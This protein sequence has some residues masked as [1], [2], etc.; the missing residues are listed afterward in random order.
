MTGPTACAAVRRLR[1]LVG[2]CLEKDPGR[3]PTPEEIVALC[4]ADRPRELAWLPTAAAARLAARR[5]EVD[6]TLARAATRPTVVRVRLTAVPLVL[7]TGIAVAVALTVGRPGSSTLTITPPE[8]GDPTASASARSTATASPSGT[9]TPGA[10]HSAAPGRSESG[11]ALSGQGA[12]G[13]RKPSPSPSASGGGTGQSPKVT[14][15]GYAGTGCA[16][17]DASSTS[18]NAQDGQHGPH[19]RPGRGRRHGDGELFL[20]T[21]RAPSEKGPCKRPFGGARLSSMCGSA[22]WARSTRNHRQSAYHQ[23]RLPRG[24]T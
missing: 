13:T 8:T 22:A 23:P 2:R 24:R 6:D 1:Q 14:W 20:K 7:A 11:A 9:P 21:P 5:K 19:R 12:A 3:R 17:A 4:G 10:R 15:T 16:S 18:F